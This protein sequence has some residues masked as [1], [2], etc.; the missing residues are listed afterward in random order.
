ILV[1]EDD[2][3]NF[4]L[5]EKLLTILNFSIVRA[6]NGEEAVLLCKE[7]KEIDLVLMDIKMPILDG[8]QA[9]LKIREFNDKVPILAQTSYSFP[10]EIEKIKE[11]GFNDYITKPIEKEEFFRLVKKY[12]KK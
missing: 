11:V 7:N 1:A 5:I 10:E 2:N 4:I 8:Y 12:M 6:K 9:F 3:I